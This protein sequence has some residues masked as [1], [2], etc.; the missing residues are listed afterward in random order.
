MVNGHPVHQ[1]EA[2]PEDAKL[3]Q[4]SNQV[5]QLREELA[6]THQEI[7]DMKLLLNEVLAKVVGTSPS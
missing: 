5:S 7:V 4:L 6:T 1:V 3:D 2:E